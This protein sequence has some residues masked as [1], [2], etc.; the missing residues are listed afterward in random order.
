MP[1]SDVAA[2][3]HK[4]HAEATALAGHLR[5]PLAQEI[6]PQAH[7]KLPCEG[8]YIAQR[9][10]D[11]KLEAVISFSSAYTH[12]AGNRSSKP[13]EGFSTLTTSVVEG[14]N[15]LDVVTADR[16]VGQI[17]TDHPLDGYVPTISFLG[18]R[19][20]NLR[21]AGHLVEVDFDHEIFGP[22]PAGDMPYT[23]VPEFLGRVTRQYERIRTHKHLP[24]ALANRYNQLSSTLGSREEVECS[25]V[26]QAAGSYPGPSFGHVIHIP[27][28]GTITLGKLTLKHEDLHDETRIPRKTTVKLTMIDLELGCVVEGNVPIGNGTSNGGH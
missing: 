16:I 26:N 6:K 12:V 7:V 15:V 2:R 28:F 17:I 10:T 5:L 19:F 13:D 25:L 3:V 20:E 11:Y 27:H 23:K 21:I 22:K 9:A 4:Y 14:L 18:T 8:G 24:E 1:M